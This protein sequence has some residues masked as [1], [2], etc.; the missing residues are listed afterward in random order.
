[1][2]DLVEEI[3]KIENISSVTEINDLEKFYVENLKLLV[4]TSLDKRN[5]YDLSNVFDLL[6]RVY[7]R[8]GQLVDDHEN[9]FNVECY[10]DAAKFFQYVVSINKGTV[11]R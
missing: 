7:I 1:M 8:K 5:Q 10:T 11:E 6:G 3:R 4:A 9:L 2:L